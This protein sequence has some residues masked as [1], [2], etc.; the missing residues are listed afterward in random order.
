MAGPSRLK[1]GEKRSIMAVMQI[2]RGFKGPMSKRVKVLSN[3]PQRPVILL[4][5]YAKIL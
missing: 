2:P 4:I 1:P 5:M 3:D